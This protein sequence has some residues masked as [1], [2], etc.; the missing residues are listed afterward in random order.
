[1]RI[2]DLANTHSTRTCPRCGGA[3]VLRPWGTCFCYACGPQ[4]L[5]ELAVRAYRAGL[6]PASELAAALG[7]ETEAQA[8]AFADALGP[9]PQRGGA[10]S[11]HETPRYEPD[12]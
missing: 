6:I 10:E 2:I 12:P 9:Q 5:E 3:A 4:L 11:T 8:I 1:M 7:V